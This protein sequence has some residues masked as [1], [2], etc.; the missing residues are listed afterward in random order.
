MSL[1]KLITEGR[2]ET[3]I[4]KYS[5]KFN[6]DQLNTILE[7]S[8]SLV[9]RN[10]FLDF[11]GKVVNP[12]NFIDDLNIVTKLLTKFSTIGSNLEVKD[13][14]QYK[15]MSELKKT[16]T[17]Y[18]DKIRREIKT[19]DDADVVYEDNKMIVV[20]PK[21]YKASCQ[22]GAGTKWCTT[23][24]PSYY[25]KYNEDAK[26]FYFIDKTKQSSDPTYKVAL[27]QKYDGDTT[28][29]NAVDDT[30]KT[31]WIFGTEKL[32]KIL[33]IITSYLNTTYAKQIKIWSDKEAAENERLRLNNEREL[34]RL[35][36]IAQ[37]QQRMRENQEWDLDNC[38]DCTTAERA[39]ALYQSLISTDNINPLTKDD[40]ERLSQAQL[41]LDELETIF[42]N[43]ENNPEL[44][45]LT[46][47]ISELE[48]EILELKE[49]KDIYNLI[50]DIFDFYEMTQFTFDNDLYAV[51]TDSEAEDSAKS[52][53]ESLLDDVG[54]G[55]FNRGFIENFIDESSVK[56]VI[57]D[58]FIHDVRE[59]PEAYLDDKN[60]DLSSSQEYDIEELMNQWRELQKKT[61]QT[62]DDDELQEIYNR[63]DEIRDEIDEIKDNPDGDYTK[64]KIEEVIE[65]LFDAYKDNVE[66]FFSDYYGVD[67]IEWAVE[68]NYI[69][70]QQLIDGVLEADGLGICLNTYDHSYDTQEVNGNTYTVIRIN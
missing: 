48:S 53:I 31:G 2:K 54:V 70:E 17:D 14:N 62:D 32:E 50:P 15:T 35:A 39:H 47:K 69:N 61:E 19:V 38:V 67:Y 7:K 13:I 20:T 40:V 68:N 60:K 41:E 5:N 59:N 6:Q 55:G 30:F 42:D 52:A 11:M 33:S 3:F 12:K 9:G 66:Q 57:E 29:F 65:N 64:S 16:L 21:T 63:V 24:S 37:E 46:S 34:A 27:L 49:K 43:S 51:G 25:E 36:A 8:E 22:F 1:D 58:F 26:L 56:D 28:Y 23:S 4:Q 45:D 44:I 10:K 18:D